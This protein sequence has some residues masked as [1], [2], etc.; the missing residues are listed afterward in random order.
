MKHTYIEDVV[1]QGSGAGSDIDNLTIDELIEFISSSDSDGIDVM[2]FRHA[3]ELCTRVDGVV[4]QKDVLDWGLAARYE[5]EFMKFLIH[6]FQ[7]T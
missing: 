1:R 4:R 6:E 2:Y 7:V 3:I 5:Q